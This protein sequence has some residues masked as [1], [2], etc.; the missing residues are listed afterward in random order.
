MIEQMLSHTGSRFFSVPECAPLKSK[1]AYD[2]ANLKGAVK[3][4][5]CPK[6]G[7]FGVL[8]CLQKAISGLGVAPKDVLVVS[9]IGCSSNLPGFFK[10]YGF[11]GIHGRALPL[12]TGMKLANPDLTVVVT[13]GD[14]DGYGIGMG[15]FIHTVRRNLNLTYCVMDN[16]IYGL[17]TGQTSPT[18]QRQMKTKSTPE[19][20]IEGP[21]NPIAL[22]LVNGATFVS[23][24]FSGDPGH[25]AQVMAKAITHRGFSLVDCFSPCVTYNKI[26]T[27]DWFK[28]RLY[29][30][31]DENHD[32]TDFQLAL[33]K[34]FE[35]GDKIPIGV[36]YEKTGAPAYEDLDATLS[37]IGS[38]V[39]QPLGLTPK[40]QK[41]L[42][43][44]FF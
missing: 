33:A 9:G 5:W 13:G 26:N 40:Q 41:E 16:Q 19:G 6:C 17:T 38:P 43:Q 22:A 25:M 8:S 37:K 24:T 15:H 27:Y 11:H 32:A 23:R 12:A 21:V 7:D 30:L 4:D 36:F 20:N 28:E 3:P 34:S 44:D 14:G 10:A 1:I 31:E 35:I 18:S 29:R 42:L 2:P 39:K